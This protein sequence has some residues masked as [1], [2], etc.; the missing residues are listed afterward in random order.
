MLTTY[1]A[2]LKGNRLEW[3]E[4]IP[5]QITPEKAIA[6]Y[7][8][9]LD[10]PVDQTAEVAQGERMAAALKQLATMDSLKE[11]NNPVAWQREIRQ[12]RNLPD[13]H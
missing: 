1:K 12:D 13:R 5:K 4:D 8:T 7:V 3:N 11:L 2:T 6:V 9:I 10:E